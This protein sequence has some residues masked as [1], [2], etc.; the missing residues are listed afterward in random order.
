MDQVASVKSE[1][2]PQSVRQ[3]L[4]SERVQEMLQA[5][6]AWQL[7]PGG[8]AIDRAFQF[9][10]PHVANA[11][12]VYVMTFAAAVGQTVNLN[13]ASTGLVVTL[14]A[15][16]KRSRRGELTEAIVNFARKLT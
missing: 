10:T 3:R 11:F 15:P 9:P 1:S 12:A 13:H 2:M 14:A 16:R 5:L 8:Q 4:K 7:V 6:P